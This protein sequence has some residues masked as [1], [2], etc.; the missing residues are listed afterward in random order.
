MTRPRIVAFS[1]AKGGAGKTVACVAFGRVLAAL[2]YRVLLVDVDADTSGLSVFLLNDVL[3][4]KAEVAAPSGAFEDGEWAIAH[5]SDGLDLLPSQYQLSRLAVPAE[6]AH[7]TLHELQSSY[8]WDFIL[9]D[10]QAGVDETALVAASVAE[11]VILVSEYDPVSAQGIKRLQQLHPIEFGS[12]AWLL[13]NKVLP[14][15]IPS[16]GDPFG[17]ERRLNPIAWDIGVVRAF[18][19]GEVPIDMDSPNAFTLSVVASLERL[20]GVGIRERV[21]AWREEAKAALRAPLERQIE[22]IEGQL[23]D[24]T[25][26]QLELM[27][28]SR[29]S[30]S[31]GQLGLAVGFAMTAAGLV[32]VASSSGVAPRTLGAIL[33]LAGPL[34]AATFILRRDRSRELKVELARVEREVGVLSE[35]HQVLRASTLDLADPRSWSEPH[36]LAFGMPSALRRRGRSA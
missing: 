27:T 12:K 32:L 3:R 31:I 34:L 16:I 15:L 24:L 23:D 29:A 28:T 35:R 1:S 30:E 21:A 7:Q 8:E 33:S 4:T 11:A 6:N 9:L 19:N 17:I 22:K 2:G 18:L 26:R 20:I 25:R 10:A 14:E 5:I 13:Y 36:A